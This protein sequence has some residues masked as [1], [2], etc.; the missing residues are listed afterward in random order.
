VIEFPKGLIT[1][2]TSFSIQAEDAK[3]QT[4]AAAEKTYGDIV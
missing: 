3:E 2:F 4:L 1:T